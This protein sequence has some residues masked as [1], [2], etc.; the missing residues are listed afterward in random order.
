MKCHTLR[1]RGFTLIE[2][3]IVVAIS[4]ILAAIAIPQYQDYVA[5]ARWSDNF[6]SIATLKQAIAE[7]VQNNSGVVTNCDASAKLLSQ[8]FVPTSPLPTPPFAVGPVTLNLITAAIVISGDLRAGGCTITLTPATGAAAITWDF[9]NDGVC[10][11]G[12]TGV[13]T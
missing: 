6:Q 9:S 10:T 8:G 11:R 1:V 3:M 13:G 5:R 4:G 2:L 7:C 12:R